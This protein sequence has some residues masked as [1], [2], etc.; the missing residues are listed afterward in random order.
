MLLEDI[1]PPSPLPHPPRPPPTPPHPT[2][3]TTPHY[4]NS[5]STSTP[6]PTTLTRPSLTTQV[7]LEDVSDAT[8]L[9]TLRL[10]LDQKKIF[11]SIGP[12]LVVVNPYQPV[13]ACGEKA[14]ARL[15]AEVHPPFPAAAPVRPPASHPRTFPP[16][17]PPPLLHLHMHPT[18]PALALAPTPPLHPSPLP[19]HWE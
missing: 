4:S 11:T 6:T 7:L 19:P 17:H 16:P 1:S 12:V 10:R 15:T 2:I 8:I 3:T 5:N 14:L 9:H 18:R 13:E